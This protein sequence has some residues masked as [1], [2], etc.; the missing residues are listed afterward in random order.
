MRFAFVPALLALASLASAQDASATTSD[1]SYR[2][3]TSLEQGAVE[4]ISKRTVNAASSSLC[5]LIGM[6]CDFQN[7]VN[8]CGKRWNVCNVIG[9]LLNG[10]GT[11]CIA[12]VCTPICNTLFDWNPL[13]QKCQDPLNCGTRGTVC[14]STW[15]NGAG[16]A[17]VNS[18]CQAKT[19][20]SGYAWSSSSLACI[21]ITSD[22]NN[23]GSCGN[24]CSFPNGKGSCVNGVCTLSS[25]TT[26]GYYNVNGVCTYYN[27]QTD[28]SHCGSSLTACP[29]TYGVAQCSSGVCGYSSCNSGYKLS[30]SSCSAINYNTDVNNCGSAGNVCPSTYTNGGAGTCVSGKCTTTCNSGYSFSSTANGCVNIKTDPNNC[31]TVG[32]VCTASNGTPSCSNGSCTVSSCNSNYVLSNG[33]CT[34][35]NTLTDTNNCGSVGNKCPS[36]YSNGIG[37]VCLLGQCRPLACNLW[38]DWDSDSNQC[39]SVF[40]DLNNCGKCGSVC[41]FTNG[42]G[43]CSSG[44]CTL[45]SCSSGFQNVNG[46]CVSMDTSS[47]VNNCGSVGNACPSTL[48][49]AKCSNSKCSYSSCNT[50][51]VLSSSG[52]CTYTN[53]QT[54]ANNCGS[55]GN[56]CPSSYANGGAGV[57]I[58]GVC[59]TNC[60]TYYAFDFTYSICRNIWSDVSN[61]GSCGNKCQAGN[62]VGSTAATCASG[63]CLATAC[64]SGYELVS[65]ACQ[66]IDLTCNV[67]NCGKLGNQCSFSPSG[68]TGA[69]V[70]STCVITSCPS[71]YTLSSTTNACIQNTASAHAK[72][73]KVEEKRTLCP[74]GETA[75]PILGSASYA[76]A[77]SHHFSSLNEFSGVMA[78]AGGYEC[79]DT[80][81]SLES[82]GGC[83]STGEGQDCTK[84]RG[85][86]GVGCDSGA[87][88]V[89]S[90]LAGWKPNLAGT[91]CVR[92]HPEHGHANSTRSAARR[93]LNARHS[94]HG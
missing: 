87:C 7:D 57:C 4:H 49:V 89:F 19:C 92:A 60:N 70:K 24:Q 75:C 69:C 45:K 51:Y 9:N 1:I 47:D 12:G 41:A 40:S 71:G 63:T 42:V 74:A 62:P 82:C 61:C 50:N 80:T 94:H 56:K 36:S 23:C 86:V 83:A 58:G 54:D 90:C 79:L 48:G 31:G 66:A 30:G 17:C 44:T 34:Y 43:V 21:G 76:L 15:S 68:A 25:C 10:K 38:Y 65:G 32:K 52:T 73:S 93:H 28:A 5:T 91:K 8:N 59:Q 33:V 11:D 3:G 72:R 29:S 27:T 22:V 85:A 53:T 13:T 46:A 14:K 39:I 2:N 78:G 88:V 20:N 6:S 18:V 67:N 77:V 81:Q 26:S 55:I 16:A 35:T 37:S 84:I 64:A